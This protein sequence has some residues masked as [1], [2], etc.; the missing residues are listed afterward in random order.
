VK[1]NNSG[2]PLAI[3]FLGAFALGSSEML[4]VGVLELMSSGLSVAVAT[5]GALVT[6]YAIG[7]AVGAPV[8]TALTIRLDESRSCCGRWPCS[9]PPT[10]PSS[11]PTTSAPSSPP[12]F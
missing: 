2:L 10:S 1:T 6:V 11:S 3:L 7:Q 4:V 9:W 8:L 5:V 12:E